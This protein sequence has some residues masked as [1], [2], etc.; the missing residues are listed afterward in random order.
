MD[1]KK[2]ENE[3]QVVKGIW[4]LILVWQNAWDEWR[5]ANFWQIN[6][7]TM[8]DTAIN[9]YK[10]FNTLNKRYIDRDWEM[11]QVTTKTVDSFRRTLP[12]ITALKNPCMRKRHWD[13]V[14]DTV[15]V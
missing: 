1:L 10:E 14:R 2:L 11:L 6:I 4:E 15:G 13:N 8:E 7:D 5:R 9:L 12:L 3:L